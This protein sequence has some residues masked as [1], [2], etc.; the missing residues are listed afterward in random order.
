M[1]ARAR[2]RAAMAECGARVDVLVDAAQ[3]FSNSPLIRA[4]GRTLAVNV[5]ISNIRQISTVFS[6]CYT[7]ILS[8]M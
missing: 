3:F 5:T 7:S 4:V 8:N 2:V 1:D 6:Q